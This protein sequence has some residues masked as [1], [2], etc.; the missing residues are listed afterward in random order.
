MKRKRKYKSKETEFQNDLDTKQKA[1]AKSIQKQ[2]PAMIEAEQ[3][4]QTRRRQQ[5]EQSF[6]SFSNSELQSK[7][8]ILTEDK[9]DKL[10]AAYKTME[11]SCKEFA[12]MFEETVV[13]DEEG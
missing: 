10:Q 6:Q 12:Q 7:R 13:H 9:L 5:K 4:L 11:H 3:V 2:I 8:K 1:I